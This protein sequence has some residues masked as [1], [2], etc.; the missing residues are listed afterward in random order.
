MKKFLLFGFIMLLLVSGIN[1][2]N[3]TAQPS[4]V[5]VAQ[6]SLP[7]S[8]AI[9]GTGAQPVVKLD[10]WPADFLYCGI[11]T[12]GYGGKKPDLQINIW[13]GAYLGSKL[14]V[15]YLLPGTD[16]K[17]KSNW[18]KLQPKQQTSFDTPYQSFIFPD[19]KVLKGRD[20]LKLR[21]RLF[22]ANLAG[23]TYWKKTK[24]G[25]ECPQQPTN[26]PLPPTETSIPP[27]ATA[28]SELPTNTPQPPTET[29][30][31]PTATATED[32]SAPLA[33]SNVSQCEFNNGQG[34]SFKL[35]FSTNRGIDVNTT[36]IYAELSASGSLEQIADIIPVTGQTNRYE[37]FPGASARIGAITVYENGVWAWEGNVPPDAPLC[38]GSTPPPNLQIMSFAPYKT[39]STNAVLPVTIKADYPVRWGVQGNCA[40]GTVRFINPG[41]LI[42]S[43][44]TDAFPEK[45]GRLNGNCDY[46]FRA[47]TRQGDYIASI[48]RSL[49]WTTVSVMAA[50]ADTGDCANTTCTPMGLTRVSRPHYMVSEQQFTMMVTCNNDTPNT[51]QG[52]VAFSE[53]SQGVSRYNI[54]VP[55]GAQPTAEGNPPTYWFERWPQAGDPAEAYFK[56]IPKDDLWG[57]NYPTLTLNVGC[58]WQ[59]GGERSRLQL[60][61]DFVVLPAA[62]PANSWAGYPI[63]L[64]LVVGW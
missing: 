13:T 18:I 51:L 36:T 12:S 43:N 32:T 7:Q 29:S 1:A 56:L 16:P 3:S 39:D 4:E 44:Y 27:T 6:G 5:S 54:D 25:A 53:N 57:G 60:I 49:D 2:H 20:K 14:Q 50:A 37:V 9:N 11:K 63:P 42:T 10:K 26:T 55:F 8:A 64:H 47:Y 46:T 59:S 23:K 38:P 52:G 41:S 58:W 15:A 21:A 48:V 24:L 33:L 34:S 19:L 31:P 45:D 28:T 62:G 40:D 17:I 61:N 35:F 30:V 22:L